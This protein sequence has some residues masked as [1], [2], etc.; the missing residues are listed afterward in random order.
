[1]DEKFEKMSRLYQA[2]Y[3]INEAILRL[4]DESHL[5]PL[6]CDIAVSLG[7]MRLAWIGRPDLESGSMTRLVSSGATAYLDGIEIFV[8]PSSDFGQGPTGHVWREG[9]NVI[10]NDFHS[11]EMTDP[12][13][14]R[15]VTNR[16]NSCGSFPIFRG[17][18][19]FAIFTAYHEQIGAFDSDVVALLDELSRDVTFALENFDRNAEI[20]RSSSELAAK[21][22]HFRAYFEHSMVGMIALT[23]DGMILEANS[24]FC[25]M[26]GYKQDELPRNIVYGLSHPDDIELSKAF[27]A[28]ASQATGGYFVLDKRYIHKDGSTIRVHNTVGVVTD[29]LGNFDYLVA[30]VEN[31]N[32]RD[33]RRN[34]IELLGRIIDNSLN[35]VLIY[36]A[37]SLRFTWANRGSL[38]NLGYSA[39][40]LN[41]MD[42]LAIKPDFDLASFMELASPL[43]DKT[44]EILVFESVRQ[45]KDGSR[46]PVEVHLQIAEVGEERFF[47][48]VVLDIT[49]RIESRDRLLT[50]ASLFTN[51]R[52]GIAIADADFRVT[53]IN[54]SFTRITGYS[55]EDAIDTYVA[56]TDSPMVFDGGFG[57]DWSKLLR[58][59]EFDG[60]LWSHRKDGFGYLNRFSIRHIRDDR[61]MVVGYAGFYKDVTQERSNEERLRNAE[62][63]DSLTGL[64]NRNS[65]MVAT[66]ELFESESKAMG[67]VALLLVNLDHFK[68]VNEAYGY[69]IGDVALQR[70]GSRFEAMIDP[71]RPICRLGGDEFAMAVATKDP[72]DALDFA[73]S[74]LG[75][76][77]QPIETEAG[78]VHLGAFIGIS[79]YPDDSSDFESLFILANSALERARHGGSNK[80]LLFDSSNIGAYTRSLEIQKSFRRALS[81]DELYLV[82][83]PIVSLRDGSIRSFE[84]LLRWN[85]P[86]LG[87]VPPSEIIRI[88]ERS[89]FIIP[90]GNWI[91][92]RALAQLASWHR[93]GVDVAMLSINVSAIQ[94][95][96]GSLVSIL[97]DKLRQYGLGNG[98]VEVEITETIAMTNVDESQAQIEKL[99]DLGVGI[100][101]DDFGTGYSSL[102]YLRK[103]P[104]TT[105]KIDQSFTSELVENVEVSTIVE[106]VIRIADALGA[107]IVAEGVETI[108]Q[109]EVLQRMGCANVQGYL[110]ARPMLPEKVAPFIEKVAQDPWYFL[111]QE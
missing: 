104:A 17:G 37:K 84:A 65:F 93:D 85:H 63:T 105:I 67:G 94:F 72:L 87:E 38:I 28:R 108:A 99:K 40:E 64:M 4:E 60:D 24:R 32:E 10:I 66:V 42:A 45:R 101:I 80:I 23:K 82:Y 43:L 79:L 78:E 51:S 44:K 83:Q 1:M 46:Y 59:G 52:E 58:N 13:K 3:E 50:A 71:K 29:A 77:N 25:E 111:C 110:I 11:S 33:E 69:S 21:E 107:E 76:I 31:V 55:E 34:R 61:E 36:E 5:F 70:L 74:V 54:S 92:S 109:F 75:L 90:L 106:S 18:E 102:S 81:N 91:I 19:I 35:E 56:P 27:L 98:V 6:I 8:D 53:A 7:G 39:L 86:K 30:A 15:A 62:M 103:F 88:A 26:L 48:A 47:V 9:Q 96:D 49:A 68:A 100:S 16:I 73:Q 14:E 95:L 89:G 20:E 22:R 57:E 41:E 97:G 12:W 2:L